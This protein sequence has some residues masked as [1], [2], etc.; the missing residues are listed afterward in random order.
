MLT[1]TL[2]LTSK[3]RRLVRDTQ[4][5]HRMLRRW[6]THTRTA[7]R[8]HQH[9]LVLVKG[10]RRAATNAINTAYRNHHHKAGT[11][12]EGTHPPHNY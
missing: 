10:D 11:R 3:A 4:A 5:V 7:G 2:T 6:W 8:R 1:T 9:V 12:D